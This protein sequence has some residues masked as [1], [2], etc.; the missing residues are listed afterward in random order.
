MRLEKDKCK[1]C[2]NCMKRCPTEAIRVREGKA[3]IISERCIDCGECIRICQNHAK[4]T[5]CDPFE[6]IYDYKYRVA[7]LAPSAYGQFILDDI[8]ILLTA[9]K[10]VGF[11]DVFEVSRAAEIVT[12]LTR[13]K[14]VELRR[15][16]DGPIISSACPVVARLIRVRFPE[17]CANVLPVNEPFQLAAQMAREEAVKKTGLAPE[18]I[19]VFFISPCPAKVTSAKSPIGIG[20]SYIDGVLSASELYLKVLPELKKIDEPENLMQSGI[21]GINW[22][23]SGGECAG[24]LSDRNLAADGIEN[25][26][27]VL[28][29]IEGDQLSD[30]DF[31][32]LN[33]CPGG[34]VGGVLNITNGFVARSRIKTL[35]KYLPL[36]QNKLS[37]D[38]QHQ[39]FWEENLQYETV[40]KLD[41]DIRTAMD[42]M[43]LIDAI[44]KT[45][46]GL[47]CGTCGAPSCRA[48]AEDIVRGEASINDCVIRF[49]EEMTK[50]GVVG[51]IP[52]PFRKHEN[53]DVKS[54]SAEEE[55]ASESDGL[56]HK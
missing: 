41:D 18:D 15:R 23:N 11:D 42:K 55:T 27:K 13:K 44:A 56:L 39:M 1:G 25:V 52:A 36:T 24:L 8:N 35:R 28:E 53:T 3:F 46:P 9:I 12:H 50:L 32:E 47:D 20:K 33:A 49:S 21:V 40:Y 6:S 48:F 31:V 54:A 7:M 30:L 4:K 43:K 34:C 10:R 2:I 16:I 51:A 17:L 26:I 45:L 38:D 37:G 19:G 14:L 22:A 29:E 5:V